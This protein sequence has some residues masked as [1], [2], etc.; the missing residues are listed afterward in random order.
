MTTKNNDKQRIL[1]VDDE[2]D[3]TIALKMYLEI[4]GFHVDTCTN[5]ANALTH[6]KVN[7]PELITI[8]C[9]FYPMLF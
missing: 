6:F 2:S 5:P 3:I 4:Q 1:I 7:I 8:H 9:D